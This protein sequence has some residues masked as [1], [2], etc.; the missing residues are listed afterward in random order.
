VYSVGPWFSALSERQA[1]AQQVSPTQCAS[2]SLRPRPHRRGFSFACVVA[3]LA[4]LHRYA[5]DGPCSHPPT[6]PSN[7]RPAALIGGAFSWNILRAGS[8][9]AWR[10]AMVSRS[11][12]GGLSFPAARTPQPVEAPHSARLRGFFMLG[13]ARLENCV[14]APCTRSD[15][16]SHRLG[17]RFPARCLTA[18]IIHRWRLFEAPVAPGYFDFN[19]PWPRTDHLP[20]FA[21]VGLDR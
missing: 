17:S 13:R 18:T 14:V 2:A 1:G 16:L 19:L 9:C 20:I 7:S 11:L 12:P 3:L 15:L 5:T 10:H 6:W 21:A 8:L 4:S